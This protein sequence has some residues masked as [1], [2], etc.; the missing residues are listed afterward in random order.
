MPAFSQQQQKLMGLALAY[1]RGDVPDSKVSPK[2]KKLADAMSEK[3]LEKYAST[4]HKGLPTK[5]SETDKSKKI[6]REELNQLVSDAVEEVMKER[7]SV[8]KLTPEQKKQY[9]EAISNYKNYENLIYRSNQL[10]Q[11]VA[12]IKS[13][14]EFASK[15][16]IEESGDWFDGISTSRNSKQ[17]KESFKE[18][19]KL[20]EKITKLQ[21]NLESIYENI[22][23]HFSRFYEIKNK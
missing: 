21:R 14:V 15:N 11:A 22:G 4:K 20:S 18:F 7:F 10:P 3:E 17:L 5:V 1:K 9:I 19:E 8:K 23:R 12:E 6:S 2:I 13:M 16:M